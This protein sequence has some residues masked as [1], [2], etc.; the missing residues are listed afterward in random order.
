MVLY[1]VGRDDLNVASARLSH[2]TSSGRSRW[3]AAAVAVALVVLGILA[4]AA[5]LD[6][7]SDGSIIELTWS[8]WRFDGVIVDVPGPPAS[9]GL[10]SGDLVTAIAGHRLADGL[11]GVAR[12]ALGTTVRYDVTRDAATSVEVTVHRPDPYPLLNQGWGNLVFVLALAGLAVALYLRRPEEPATAPLLVL[13]AGLLGSTLTVVAGLP[14]LALATAGPQLW[15]FQLN[16]IGTY[17]VAWG[18]LLAFSLAVTARHPWLRRGRHALTVA[19][20]APLAV[21]VIWSAVAA[22]LAPDS[23]R[24]LGLV[25]GGQTAVVAATLVTGIISGVVGYR[26]DR[27]PL[28]RSRLRW[29]AGGGTLAGLLGIVGWQLPE[30]ITGRHPLPWGA[31]GLSALPFVGGIA[32]ALRRHRL[33]DIERLANRSLVYAATVAVLVAG[34][35]ATVALLVSGLRLSD[36][37]AAALAAA[38]A[39]LVLAP[40]RNAAQHAVNRVMYGDRQDPVAAL[41]RLGERLQA[42]MLPAD[43]L[44][45]VVETVARSLRVP[46]PGIE[47]V[48][49]AGGYRVAA[50]HGVA[51][52][53]VHVEP[54]LHHGATVG[55]LRVSARGRDDPLDAV[56]LTLIRS[57]AQQV[58]PAVQAVRL[59]DDLVRSRAEVVA[60]REDERRRLRRDLHDGLGPTLA[61][62]RLK[63]DL[64]ARDL[65]AGSVAYGLLGEISAEAKASLTDVRRLVEALR[66]PAL[67]ELGLVAAVR[68]RATALAGEISIEVT[69]PA[70]TATLPAAVETAAY[71]IA[72]EAITNAVRHSGG[73]HCAVVI[74]P[75]DRSVEVTVRDDGHGL[76]AA[77]TPGVGLRSMRERAAEV[78][79]VWSIRSLPEGG[80]VVHAW[81]PT[82]FGGRDDPADTR[83]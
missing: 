13:A 42:V 15:L 37:V 61:A 24:W 23:V 6:A 82:G 59:H 14:A 26:G 38:G 36:T 44:P 55:R 2:L 63:A 43:V 11:G 29:L 73:R 70:A 51:V 69:G 25:H 30:L 74:T 10:D 64:A 80:T 62:I 40:L 50:E 27:D 66:P 35:A 18:A 21:M 39:A 75:S 67:D 83:R 12:P 45:A 9:A 8:S 52:G 7:P 76:N 1:S 72:V 60:L 58:G 78:G 77:G 22:M 19:Y 49:G 5:R 53:A 17:S 48:D 54:L 71:R 68:S 46:Y 34:Y 56:D 81:L 32:V 4:T 28:M 33:F 47:L 3:T 16:A 20:A 65:P 31:L 57:L 41:A 79:G